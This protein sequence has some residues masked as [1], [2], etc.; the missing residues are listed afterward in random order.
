MN[1]IFFLIGFSVSIIL[2]FVLLETD[3]LFVI[4]GVVVSFFTAFWFFTRNIAIN[5]FG[6]PIDN[7][8]IPR[9]PGEASKNDYQIQD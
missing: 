1:L 8:Y 4:G 5:I 6:L 7:E 3:N 2:A 9:F